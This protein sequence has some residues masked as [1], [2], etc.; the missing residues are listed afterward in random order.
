MDSGRSKTAP[1]YGKSTENDESKAT[2]LII[3]T[4]SQLMHL[5]PLGMS[6]K[7]CRRLSRSKDKIAYAQDAGVYEQDRHFGGGVP[8]HIGL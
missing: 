7:N 1:I 2:T 5:S 4:E 8:I 3:L 6:Q